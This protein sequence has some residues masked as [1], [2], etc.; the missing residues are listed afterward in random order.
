MTT[1]TGMTASSP[2]T[3]PLSIFDISRIARSPSSRVGLKPSPRSQLCYTGSTA[4]P[5]F[6]DETSFE[7]DEGFFLLSP[8]DLSESDD[9]TIGAPAS[10]PLTR[11][12]L[13]R[14]LSDDWSCIQVSREESPMGIDDASTAPLSF[15]RPRT[16]SF[17]LAKRSRPFDSDFLRDATGA[18]YCPP[19]VAT[20]PAE[21]QFCYPVCIPLTPTSPQHGNSFLARSPPSLHHDYC[22]NI[23]FCG[24]ANSDLLLPI[25]S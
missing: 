17:V 22:E 18:D 13:P 24:G 4:T 15:K 14:R 23:T 10:S 2:Q 12:L 7:E 20:Q 11:R 21:S 16:G 9:F 8:E 19:V 25:L 3:M 5:T 6:V 1:S